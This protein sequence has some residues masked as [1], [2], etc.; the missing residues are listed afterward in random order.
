MR[1]NL[2]TSCALA[3]GLVIAC[4]N[5]LA[6]HGSGVSYDM[7]KQISMTGTVTK[8]QWTNPH[9]Y[10]LYTVKDEGGNTVLWGAE[11]HPPNMMVERGWNMN[12]LKP[13]DSIVIT[14][15]PSK[16][17]T[18]RGLLAKVVLNGKVLLDDTGRVAQE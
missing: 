9:V 8:V 15:F 1:R 2:L 6:H 4:G 14:V 18:P 11:S 12:S 17:G 13:G 10:I 5:M 3:V 16:V 7:K